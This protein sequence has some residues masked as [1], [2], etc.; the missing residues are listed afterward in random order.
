MKNFVSLAIPNAPS[1]DSEQTAHA[2]MNYTYAHMYEDTFSDNINALKIKTAPT[3]Y[4]LN[5]TLS[6]SYNFV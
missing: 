5:L 2:D 6:L 3:P 1:D 4:W